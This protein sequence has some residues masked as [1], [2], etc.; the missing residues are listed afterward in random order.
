MVPFLCERDA[1]FGQEYVY[2]YHDINDE[3]R[4]LK[5]GPP[6]KN[7]QKSGKVIDEHRIKMIGIFSKTN[8]H[9]VCSFNEHISRTI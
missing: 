4:S 2:V 1:I 5:R 9:I 3:I 7:T 8:L 6:R